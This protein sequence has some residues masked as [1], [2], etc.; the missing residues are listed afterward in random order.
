[1]YDHP[2]G[3]S[4]T[5]RRMSIELSSLLAIC[6]ERGGANLILVRVVPVTSI[7]FTNYRP[8]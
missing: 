5:A 4:E 8:K 7:L 3:S 1:M 2:H 6:T